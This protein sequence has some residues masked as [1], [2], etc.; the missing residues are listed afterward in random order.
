MARRRQQASSVRLPWE[1]RRGIRRFLER[2][3]L[4]VVLGLLVL[5]V[6]AL[7]VTRA[8]A[9]RQRRSDTRATIGQIHRAVSR[10]RA[11]LGRCPRNMTEMLHPPRG[12]M[13]YLHGEPRD[14]WGNAI[15]L[16]CPAPD[17]PDTQEV[18]S[19]GPSGDFL[20]DDNIQ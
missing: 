11:D 16:T 10:F 18:V 3:R 2:S 8:A 12:R 4:S 19:A 17:D 13:T 9:N 5:G 20:V 6:L 14:A 15:L 7:L 1:D